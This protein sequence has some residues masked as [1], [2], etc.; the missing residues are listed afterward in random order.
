[1]PFRELNASIVRPGVKGNPKF[2]WKKR[3]QI[4]A[5][6]GEGWVFVSKLAEKIKKISVFVLIYEKEYAIIGI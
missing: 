5:R 3:E 2:R 4:G 6:G 1:M